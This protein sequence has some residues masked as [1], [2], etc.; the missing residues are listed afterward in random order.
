MSHSDDKMEDTDYY[1]Y[2][3]FQ[4]DYSMVFTESPEKVSFA[5]ESQLGLLPGIRKSFLHNNAYLAFA[6]RV[7]LTDRDEWIHQPFLTSQL[8]SWQQPFQD[9]DGCHRG[10]QGR[11]GKV[12]GEGRQESFRTSSELRLCGGCTWQTWPPRRPRPNPWKLRVFPYSA[13]GTHDSRKD[14]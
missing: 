11:V 8:Q 12:D 4:G 5:H 14:F 3:Y 6:H 9:R 2:T 1:M 10:N 13:Y 7:C